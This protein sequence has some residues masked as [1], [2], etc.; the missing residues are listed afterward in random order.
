MFSAAASACLKVALILAYYLI[1]FQPKRSTGARDKSCGV[2]LTKR[3][4]SQFLPC[5]YLPCTFMQSNEICTQVSPYIRL[6]S[7]KISAKMIQ[8]GRNTGH[9]V[10][11]VKTRF[12]P[13]VR[14]AKPE[15]VLME[16]VLTVRV[17]EQGSAL[18]VI[19]RNTISPNSLS[20]KTGINSPL[21]ESAL[22]ESALT[23]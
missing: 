12:V 9:G 21:Q 14:V 7:H 17:A 22:A 20:Y 23:V 13:I 1:K 19:Y 11:V 8:G 15:S 3:T 5:L 16:S 10:M 2:S 18:T 6:S 4:F